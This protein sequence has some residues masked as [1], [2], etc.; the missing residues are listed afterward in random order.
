MYVTNIIV[1]EKLNDRFLSHF[2]Y[3][4]EETPEKI[5]DDSYCYT[6]RHESKIRCEYLNK[7]VYDFFKDIERKER[8]EA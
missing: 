3:F 8:H 4:K 7:E 6:F 5:F 1:P 2:Q